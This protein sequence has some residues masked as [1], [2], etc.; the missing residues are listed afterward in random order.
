M[1]SKYMSMNALMT[2]GIAP[3]TTVEVPKSGP[4]LC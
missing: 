1:L 3:A 2:Y 4:L